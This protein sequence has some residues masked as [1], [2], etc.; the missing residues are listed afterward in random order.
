M[1]RIAIVL[2]TLYQ[3][4]IS[5]IIKQLFGDTCRYSPSC[6]EYAKQSI[7]KYGIIKGSVLGLEQLLRCHPF[8]KSFY[9]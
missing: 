2:I 8:G 6:S 3:A 9:V 1:Q 4:F 7:Q 5:P